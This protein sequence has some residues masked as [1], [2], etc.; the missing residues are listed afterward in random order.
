[1]KF[2]L[3]LMSGT[4][5]DGI[6]AALIDENNNFIDGLT[7]PYNYQVRD[8]ILSVSQGE[9][10]TIAEFNQLHTLIGREFA[11]AARELILRHED[12]KPWIQAIG[13]H[14]QT[15]CHDAGAQIPYT[16]QL[17]CGHTIAE[18]TGITVVADF[19]TRD[20]IVGGEG[21]PFA[22]AYHQEIF[23]H[24]GTPLAIVN[25]G[26][27]SNITCLHNETA[28]SGFD[29]GP[30]NCL[31]DQWISLHLGKSYDKN[32]EWAGQGTIIRELVEQL[33]NDSYF[34]RPAPKSIGKEYFS[35]DWLSRY[36]K[37]DYHPEDVQASLLFLTAKTIAMGIQQIFPEPVTVLICGGGAHNNELLQSLQALLSAYTVKSSNDFNIHADY[38]EAMMFAWFAAKTMNQI[39]FNLKSI[40]GA[41]YPA[42]LGAI[43]P[44]GIDK[45]NPN[46]CNVPF[47]LT[48]GTLV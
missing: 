32:G 35:L 5:M 48:L 9:K 14:G 39:P 42:I 18:A 33:L 41:K 31:M 36:L 6:D 15:L 30:G 12:K 47:D 13:S 28:I 29:L 23:R 44:A 21:A 8:S 45:R 40:T 22:P 43:Y 10:K 46:G 27:I 38:I 25:I 24:L 37:A 3:G 11:A 34:K 19:R 26:G 1:M 2:Y 4:S 7:R 20:L 16:V 17:G